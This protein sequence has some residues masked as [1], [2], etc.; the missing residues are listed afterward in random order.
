VANLVVSQINGYHYCQAAHT[1]I[2]KMEHFIGNQILQ[3]RSSFSDWDLKLDALSKLT[4]TIT[5]ST[6]TQVENALNIFFN[7]GYSKGIV[8]DLLLI[9]ANKVVGN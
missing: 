4:K 3:I 8:V 9:V 1:A 2:A 6:G 7:Q 5:E